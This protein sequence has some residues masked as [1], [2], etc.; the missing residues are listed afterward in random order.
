MGPRGI[1]AGVAGH[2][3]AGG[4]LHR[5][6]RAAIADAER[7]Y[8]PVGQFMT[9]G[10]TRLH[11][12]I[13]GEGENAMLGRAGLASMVKCSATGPVAMPDISRSLIRRVLEPRGP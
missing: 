12:V 9:A 11:Y 1:L 3:L 5:Y 8:P 4:A 7:R 13:R 2:A 10:G 6:N